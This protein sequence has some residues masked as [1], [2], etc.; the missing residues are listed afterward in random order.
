MFK[1]VWYVCNNVLVMMMVM[2][3]LA[4][5]SIFY[6]SILLLPSRLEVVVGDG[7]VV[8]D[9]DVKEMVFHFKYYVC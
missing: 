8:D 5:H 9:D 3:S 4:I 2:T 7:G 6:P 1:S